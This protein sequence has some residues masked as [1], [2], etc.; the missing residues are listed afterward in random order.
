MLHGGFTK[1]RE[2]IVSSSRHYCELQ[3]Y[4]SDIITNTLEGDFC[5]CLQNIALSRIRLSA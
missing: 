2:D 4:K 1:L 5:C 3:I